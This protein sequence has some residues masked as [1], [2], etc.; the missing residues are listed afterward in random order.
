[1]KTDAIIKQNVLDELDWEPSIDAVKIGVSV[2]DGIVTLS[3]HVNTYAEKMFAEKAAKRVSGVKAVVEEIDVDILGRDKNSDQ[4]IA[5]TALS[6]L[7]WNTTVPHEKIKL[8]VEDGWITLEGEVEWNFQRDAARNCIKNLKGVRG[9]S[10]LITVKTA[11]E[12][13][14]VKQKIKNAFERNATIDA[15]SVNVMVEGH[16]VVLSGSVQSWAEKRQAEKAAWSAPGV[17]QVEDNLRISIKE[18]AY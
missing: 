9:V 18:H 17:T 7:R 11:V 14:N 12:P 1:M 6:N 15:D 3:G 4:D 16:K 13:Q 2:E 8:K 10:N 5:Q